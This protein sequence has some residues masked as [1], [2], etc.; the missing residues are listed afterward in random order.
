MKRFG[1]AEETLVIQMDFNF[2]T[3]IRLA[4][5]MDKNASVKILMQKVFDINHI[6]YQDLFKIDLP[7]FLKFPGIQR[8]YD[9]LER[10]YEEQ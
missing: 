9:F 5:E 6:I 1:L 4:M 3:T 7:I 8:F 10:D 2:V